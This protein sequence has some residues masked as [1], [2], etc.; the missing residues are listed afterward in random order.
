MQRADQYGASEVAREELARDSVQR[1]RLADYRARLLEGPTVLLRQSRLSRSFNPQQL[2]AFDSV[3]T[4]FPT[5]RF[6][7]DWGSLEVSSGG[8][9]VSNDMSWLRLQVPATGVAQDGST[10]RGEGWVLTLAS[11]WVLRPLARQA[12]SYEVVAAQP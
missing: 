5:G 3:T 4:V 10:V 7:A 9:L 2:V 6:G 11:G 1:A 8:A 12:G